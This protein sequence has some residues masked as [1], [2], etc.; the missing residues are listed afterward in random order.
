MRTLYNHNEVMS[1][2]RMK[3]TKTV[4]EE[5]KRGEKEVVLHHMNSVDRSNKT[6]YRTLL[7]SELT[8]VTVSDFWNS[9]PRN[10]DGVL[11]GAAF[12]VL[13]VVCVRKKSTVTVRDTQYEM[14]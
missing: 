14:L 11:V 8:N 5:V 6:I 7:P 13:L 3:Y 9:L 1:R 2:I 12:P 4:A 10:H